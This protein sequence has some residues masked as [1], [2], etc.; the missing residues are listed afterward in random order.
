MGN[1][2]GLY[3]HIP[4]CSSK[5]HYCAFSVVT[6]R[7]R[8]A[9]YIHIL[10]KEL[11]QRL[12]NLR[13]EDYID[14]VYIGGGTPSLLSR[15]L[16]QQVLKAVFELCPKKLIQEVTMEC[17]PEQVTPIF[18][19]E[20]SDDG[21]SRISMGIQT[22]Q[23]E[24]LSRF[25]RQHTGKQA[26]AALIHLQNSGLNWN[27]DLILGLPGTTP[28]NT[29]H[30]LEE[31]LSFNPSHLSAYFL[32]IE[33][34]TVLSSMKLEYLKDASLTDLYLQVSKKLEETGYD[35]VE[36]SN[37]AKPN[38][39]C[40]HNMHYWRAE[41]YIGVGLGASTLYDRRTFTN[42]KNLNLYLEEKFILETPELL[43]QEDMVHLLLTTYTRCKEGLPWAELKEHASKETLK[44]LQKRTQELAHEGL[45]INPDDGICL[46]P[47]AYP[48]HDTILTFLTA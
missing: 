20:V 18:L 10:I 45:C 46:H 26:R 32:S 8:E 48:L 35:H 34:G 1:A 33:P 28:E 40:K 41:E 47:S 17:N 16:R 42:T 2:I 11:T 37:W 6:D 27:T 22:L 24:V 9:E 36:I 23:D 4:F 29:L 19:Q 13:K 3:I 25:N 43:D 38:H 44:R 7:S 21:I 39:A 14:T 31:V 30:D 12:Q 15:A 5:C